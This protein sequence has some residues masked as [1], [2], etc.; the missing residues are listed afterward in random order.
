[1]LTAER[2]SRTIARLR[3][4]TFTIKDTKGHE[5]T[6]LLFRSEDAAVFHHEV[7]VFEDFDVTERVGV[8]RN[9]VSVGA[10]SHDSDLSVHIEHLSG[11]GSRALDG[12]HRAHP[13]LDHAGE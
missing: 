6:L 8:H 10:G 1:M 4:K 12:I 2:M 11:A 7:D 13:E 9:D 5:V 3:S